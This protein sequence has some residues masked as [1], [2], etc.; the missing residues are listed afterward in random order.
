MEEEI[1]T[2]H[3][4]TP[5]LASDNESYHPDSDHEIRDGVTKSFVVPSRSDG[6]R[7]VVA[8]IEAHADVPDIPPTVGVVQLDDAIAEQI[9]R[10][11]HDTRDPPSRTTN[12]D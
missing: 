11:I 2:P 5:E 12:M 6:A 4:V 7:K 3:V 1:P 9:A 10:A 8:S